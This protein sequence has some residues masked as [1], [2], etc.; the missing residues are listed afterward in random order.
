MRYLKA[1]KL[2]E[3]E[4]YLHNESINWELINDA[5]DLSL[6]NLD[7]GLSLEY[8]VDYIKGGLKPIII[9]YYSLCHKMCMCRHY[10]KTQIRMPIIHHDPLYLRHT[11]DGCAPFP[12]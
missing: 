5:K 6:D 8:K 7:E 9:G 11:V 2:F 1:Y 4:N 10:D 3:S 12:D